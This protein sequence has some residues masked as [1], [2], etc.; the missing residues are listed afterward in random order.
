LKILLQTF[1]SFG[2]DN[3]WR[4]NR[5]VCEWDKQQE[6]EKRSPATAIARPAPREE[7]RDWTRCANDAGSK[8]GKMMTGR[9]C[10]RK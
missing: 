10:E 5:P 2:L 4:A 6:R 3:A 9:A 1:T 7:D 8:A